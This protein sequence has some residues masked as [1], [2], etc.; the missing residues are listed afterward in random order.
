MSEFRD[1]SI[2]DLYS[3]LG[4]ER[5]SSKRKFEE[6]DAAAQ[7]F[8]RE[9]TAHGNAISLSRV[10]TDA[11]RLCALSFLEEDNRGEDFWPHN[12]DGVLT[13]AFEDDRNMY[14]FWPMSPLNRSHIVLTSARIIELLTHIFRRK[15][16][17]DYVGKME[18]IR[19]TKAV[20]GRCSSEKPKLVKKRS[21]KVRVRLLSHILKLAF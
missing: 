7:C 16:Y 1:L 14:V 17:S 20:A 6:L 15:N 2:K 12:S 13:W 18:K 11:A 5:K 3:T 4:Y 8:L 21:K 9:Y 19:K 10:D